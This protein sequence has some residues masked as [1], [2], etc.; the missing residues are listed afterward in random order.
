MLKKLYWQ[1]YRDQ[2]CEIEWVEQ[3]IIEKL[4]LKSYN[5]NNK[6][7]I[8][9]FDI[10]YPRYFT[11]DKNREKPYDPNGYNNDDYTSILYFFNQIVVW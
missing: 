10:G 11:N 8:V 7:K 9:V 6:Y 2:A 3:V 1:K 4:I 5:N